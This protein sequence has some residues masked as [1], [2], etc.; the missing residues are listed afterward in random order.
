[1]GIALVRKI[2]FLLPREGRYY[3]R[4][5]VPQKLRS[6]I[7]KNELREPLGSDRRMAIERLPIAMVKINAQ[8]DH[9]RNVLAAQLERDGKAL[10]KRS[11]PMTPDELARVHYQERLD[12][13]AALRDLSDFWASRSIDDGYVAQTRAVAAGRASNDEI[14]SLLGDVLEKYARRG[15]FSAGFGSSEWRQISRAIADAE[16]EALERT[17]QRDE[18]ITLREEHHPPHLA[19]TTVNVE[20]EPFVE[21]VSLRGLLDAHLKALEAEGR[22]RS[23]R[24]AWT[25]PTR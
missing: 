12:L 11:A 21:P 8:I 3:A 18:G 2:P 1:M 5:I 14:Y 10:A 24:K 6:I 4:R 16:L 17:L 22:G 25:P 19:P 7:G 15:N 9:A 23:A 13:D 20:I